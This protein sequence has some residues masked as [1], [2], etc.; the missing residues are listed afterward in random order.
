[1]KIKIQQAD[2]PH[3]ANIYPEEWI[4][5]DVL[6]INCTMECYYDVN[7]IVDHYKHKV[8]TVC[9]MDDS[10]AYQPDCETHVMT[11]VQTTSD[12][13]TFVLHSYDLRNADCNFAFI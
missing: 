13:P 9:I 4:D 11:H 1:M 6:V 10:Y 3:F 5:C 7:R 8:K 2:L 12:F